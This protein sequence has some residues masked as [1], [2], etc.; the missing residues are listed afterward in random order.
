MIFSR[1]KSKEVKLLAFIMERLRHLEIALE[2]TELRKAKDLK[3]SFS[4]VVNESHRLLKMFH[5]DVS[6][7]WDQIRPQHSIDDCPGR[8]SQVFDASNGITYLVRYQPMELATEVG[9]EHAI[10]QFDSQ[11]DADH[12]FHKDPNTA[13]RWHVV[14]RLDKIEGGPDGTDSV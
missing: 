8:R 1:L 7:V 3:R 13:S 4:M 2:S 5:V 6:D 12:F 11:F 9:R 14:R 10:I